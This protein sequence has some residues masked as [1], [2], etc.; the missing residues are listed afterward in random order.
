MIRWLAVVVALIVSDARESY[1]EVDAAISR[2]QAI[3]QQS[4]AQCH[5][6]QGEGN[7]DA[8]DQPLAGDASI[9]EIAELITETM[10]EEDPEAC[11][12]EEAELVAKYIWETFYQR[13]SPQD[14]PRV[15][16]ARLTAR[17]LRHS[18]NDLYQRF[19]DSVPVTAE[20]GLDARYYNRGKDD[21]KVSFKRVDPVIDFDFGHDGP[22]QGINPQDFS[23]SW[24]GAIR[25]DE[26]GTYEFV[27]RCENSFVMH[28]G[29]D[30]REFI[31]N[32]VQSAERTE[33]RVA[34]FL[35]AGMVYPV[36]IQLS[37]RK[38]KTEQPPVKIALSWK[39]P[40]GVEQVIP[41]HALLNTRGAPTFTL[42]T[43]LPADDRSYGYERGIAVDEQWNAATTRAALEFADAV[44]LE[45]WPD[46]RR[47]HRDDENDQRQIVRGFLTELV[48]TAFRGPLDDAVHNLYVEQHLAATESDQ[49]AI[50]R[51]L[52]MALKSPRFLY[53]L[54]DDNQTPSQQAANRLALTMHDSLPSDRWLLNAIAENRL[55]TESQIRTAARRMLNDW[56][57]RAKV[58]KLL[59]SWLNFDH[60]DDLSKSAERQ[61]EFTPEL[62]VDLRQSMDRFLEYVVWDDRSDYRQ[63]LLSSWNYTT[64]R[65]AEVYGSAWAAAE[66]GNQASRSVADELHMGVLS[67]PLLMSGLAYDDASSPIHRGVFLLRFA[68]G[69][70]LRPPNEAFTPFSPD[71]HPN[72]TTRERVA[73]Q[74]GEKSCQVCHSKINGL[75]FTLENFDAIGRYQSQQVGR[76]IDASGGYNTRDGQSVNFDGPKELA[77]FLANH[78]DAHR[79][80]VNRAFQHM[81]KQPLAA[82]GEGTADRLFEIFRDNDCNIQNLLVEVAVIAA[83]PQPTPS[84]ATIA[85]EVS[86]TSQY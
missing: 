57:T 34:Q 11:V 46:Y 13:Q 55:Q 56:R 49:E 45:A 83:R 71:L 78:E 25:P 70:T 2:G 27:V 3:Y 30:R 79:A 42:Q 61:P 76:P 29:A 38:R 73:L 69:R 33:F 63:L 24:R 12:G 15:R 18:L 82:Y 17:Q 35:N 66:E 19:H 28:F 80:F 36:S 37:Q 5:G 20:R 31:N 7:P 8:Y 81:V 6:Q 41:N 47:R 4:C 64:P 14:R 44:V 59:H 51:V 68:L 85:Q 67:H 10:P 72:L 48:Q 22:G 43:K 53:P 60:F 1:G 86:N 52:L 62:Q 9:T 77:E 65:I 32:H 54:I 39:T 16:L 26:T 21:E 40:R 84:K 23:I 58:R 75:G 50:K 74:T